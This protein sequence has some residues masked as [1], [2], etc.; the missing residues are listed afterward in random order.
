MDTETKPLVN[1]TKS[2]ESLRSGKDKQEIKTT[3]SKP[4]DAFWEAYAELW[5]NSSCK[6]PFQSPAYLRSLSEYVE[7]QTIAF[8]FKKSDHLVGAVVFQ[9][10][11]NLL[12]F[13]SD[14]KSDYNSFIFRR[15]L[16][17]KEIRKSIQ[18]FLNLV[19]EAGISILLNKHPEE[20]SCHQAMRDILPEMNM[21]VRFV[22]YSLCPVLK[23]ESPELLFQEM[24]RSKNVRYKRNRLLRMPDTH[25]EILTDES[26]LTGWCD[27]YCRNHIKRWEESATP[28]RYACIKEQAGIMRFLTAWAEDKTLVRFAIVQDGQRIALSAGLL[29]RDSFIGHLQSF[30]PVYKKH[31]LGNVLI[32]LIGKWL[33]DQGIRKINFGDGKDN[34]KYSFATESIHLKKIYL[35]QNQNLPLRVRAYLDEKYR[36]NEQIRRVASLA[37]SRLKIGNIK[38]F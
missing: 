5:H 19:R 31:S 11:G 27:A 15:D 26:D 32:N 2:T 36:S 14:V 23:C 37:K 8:Q 33:M 30:D 34:Y 1:L 17:R 28:S 22:P 24:N 18:G 38:L 6:S 10:D 21:F 25:L 3:F 16:N 9:D 20:S 13:L 12:H 4:D 29:S 7:A 35:S